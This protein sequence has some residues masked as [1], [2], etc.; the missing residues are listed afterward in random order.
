MI[1]SYFFFFFSS[2]RRHTRLQGDWS[3]DVC[4]SDLQ[5]LVSPVPD[6]GR[7]AAHGVV[8]AQGPSA[9]AYAPHRKS[10][11]AS[12]DQS[13]AWKAAPGSTIH[14]GEAVLLAI[15]T[16]CLLEPLSIAGLRAAWMVVDSAR[17]GRNDGGTL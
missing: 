2:R 14:G 12:Q 13:D 5:D 10:E 11:R 4:A 8:D 1:F 16:A 17:S 9:G 3:S 15:R 7:I 6:P